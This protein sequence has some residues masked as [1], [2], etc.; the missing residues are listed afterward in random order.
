MHLYPVNGAV[1]RVGKKETPWNSRDVNWSMVILGVDPDPVNNQKITDWTKQYWEA[2]RPYSAGGAYVNF[3]M[4]EGE[5]R[6][7]ETYGGNFERLK[8]IKKKYDP[9]NLFRLNQNIK[10]LAKS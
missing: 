9:D 8:E 6:V 2:M 3:M 5:A 10:P 1:S 7:K 4:E